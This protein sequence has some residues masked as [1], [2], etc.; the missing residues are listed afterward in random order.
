MERGSEGWALTDAG[1]AVAESA[2]AIEDA[3]SRAV[4]AVSG[5]DTPSL[6]GTVRVNAPDGFGTVFATPALAR[7]RRCHPGLQT[8]LITATRQLAL[9]PSGFDLALAIGKTPGSRLV[10]EH[11]TDYALGLYASDAY[12]TRCGSPETLADLLRR[13]LPDEVDIRLPI[14]LAVRREAVTHPA[15]RAVRDALHQ[16][17]VDRAAELLPE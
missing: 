10:T 14:T 13:L 8:E 4:D 9:H 16:E 11:L 15:V 1:K 6:R 12:L 17:V 5:Q 3:L 7:V 2:R